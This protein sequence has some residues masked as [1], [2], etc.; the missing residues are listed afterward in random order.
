[1]I[2]VAILKVELAKCITT[3]DKATVAVNRTSIEQL[4]DLIKTLFTSVIALSDE[5]TALRNA[6]LSLKAAND[7]HIKDMEEHRKEIT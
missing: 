7:G 5:V 6:N 1:M 3:S 4:N 2:D